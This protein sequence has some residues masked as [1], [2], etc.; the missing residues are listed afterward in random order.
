VFGDGGEAGSASTIRR[1]GACC[2]GPVV[3]AHCVVFVWVMRHYAIVA[4]RR[5]HQPAPLSE[6]RFPPC[7]ENWPG[8][9]MQWRHEWFLDKLYSMVALYVQDL[10]LISIHSAAWSNPKDPPPSQPHASRLTSPPQLNPHI[11]HKPQLSSNNTAV[12]IL[13]FGK[14][15]THVPQAGPLQDHGPHS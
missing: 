5:H 4:G 12:D 8:G 15:I 14:L 10:G 11:T 3:V 6:M 2:G 9:A 1:A 7:G 13:I